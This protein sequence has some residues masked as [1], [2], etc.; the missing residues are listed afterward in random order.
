MVPPANSIIELLLL[1]VLFVELRYV[2]AHLIA[3]GD[4]L[5]VLHLDVLGLLLLR[6][7]LIRLR[8]VHLRPLHLMAVVLLGSD[9]VLGDVGVSTFLAEVYRVVRPFRDVAILLASIQRLL[10]LQDIR[11]VR[12]GLRVHGIDRLRLAELVLGLIDFYL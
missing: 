1:G 9:Q 8:L 4:L 5:L 6:R 11:L 7:R 2:E 12:Q 3:V 10:H